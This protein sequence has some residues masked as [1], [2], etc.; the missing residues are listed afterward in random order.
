LVESNIYPLALYPDTSGIFF[1][2][3]FIN[4][5][6]NKLGDLLPQDTPYKDYIRV[7]NVAEVTPNKLLRVVMSAE[8]ST[9]LGYL[10][11]Y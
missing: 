7:I 2:Y 9:A 11:S 4:Q 6:P 8:E 3:S 10:H 1:N 5:T